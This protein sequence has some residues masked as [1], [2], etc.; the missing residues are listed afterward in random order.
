[1]KRDAAHFAG[2]EP[3]LIF[4]AKR[5]RDAIALEAVLDRA[6][7]DYGVESDEYDGGVIFRTKRVGAFFYVRP[8]ARES[9]IALLLDNGY[10]P[11]E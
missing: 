11:A 2:T 3:E 10:V 9:A 6:G 5:L 4:V 1:M 8:E 7:I